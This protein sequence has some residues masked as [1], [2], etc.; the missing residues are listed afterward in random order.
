M[1]AAVFADAGSLFNA[2]GRAKAVVD[3]G[4]L[5]DDSTVRSSVGGSILWNSPVGPLR[6]DFAHALTKED[7]DDEQFFR[8]G[9]STKF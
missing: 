7:Y 8:F 9:A 1:G 3:P 6:V 2:S 4:D 5:L